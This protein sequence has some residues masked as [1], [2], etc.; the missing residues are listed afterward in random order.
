MTKRR[1][2]TSEKIFQLMR[3]RFG[4]IK[5]THIRTIEI[6]GVVTYR[7]YRHHQVF[8]E[9]KTPTLMLRNAEKIYG[10]FLAQKA[11][12][13][14]ETRKKRRAEKRRQEILRGIRRGIK[15]ASAKQCAE[16]YEILGDLVS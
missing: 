8:G 12:R 9:G 4:N 3:L 5:C 7:V 15:F 14:E 10:E 16:I 2:T 13:E 6:N 1:L 11:E